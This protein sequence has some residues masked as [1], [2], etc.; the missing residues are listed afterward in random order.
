MK[1]YK[2]LLFVTLNIIMISCMFMTGCGKNINL[3]SEYSKN[4]VVEMKSD[5]NSEVMVVTTSVGDIEMNYLRF[6]NGVKTLI[7]LPGLSIKPVTL[8]A[9]AVAQ[10]FA[11]F[12]DEYTVYLFDRRTNIPGTYSI[13]EMAEDTAKVIRALGI[14]NAD[15]FGTSQGGMIAMSI[16]I[17]YPE[18]VNKMVLGSTAARTNE[19]LQS[20]IDDWISLAEA[21]DGYK[22]NE[23]VS[24]AIY[25]ETVYADYKDIILAAGNDISEEEMDRFVI[26]ASSI[27]S[28]DIYDELDKITCE[29]LVIG[30]EGDRVTTADASREIAEKLGCEYY[31]YDATYG[32]A[33]YDEAPDYRGRLLEFFGL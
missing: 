3:D 17:K 26:L 9:Q 25:S 4:E 12:T 11:D 31:F 32:H 27:Y 16:A 8:S 18:I 14:E 23:V 30:S 24:Q 15:F 7:I 29:V 19:N 10:G 5:D 13:D 28:L 22:L 2:R 20:V 6:G 33:V 1:K 21:K